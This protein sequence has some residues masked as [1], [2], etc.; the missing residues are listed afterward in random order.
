MTHEEFLDFLLDKFRVSPQVYVDPA[1]PEREDEA[2][3]RR[4]IKALGRF[5]ASQGL[6]FRSYWLR[7]P[8]AF[9]STGK[10]T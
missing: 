9:L 6:T 4:M 10:Q 7:R 3:A 8:I 5:L 1:L 2:I